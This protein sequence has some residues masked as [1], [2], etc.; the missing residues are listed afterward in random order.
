MTLLDDILDFGLVAVILVTGI[1]IYYEV[2]KEMKKM[3]K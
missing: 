1:W 3:V 2:K